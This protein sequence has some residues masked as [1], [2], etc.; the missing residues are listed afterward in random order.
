[1]TIDGAEAS[2]GKELLTGSGGPNQ[3]ILNKSGK[4]FKRYWRKKRPAV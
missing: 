4:K 1:M 2:R 3:Q